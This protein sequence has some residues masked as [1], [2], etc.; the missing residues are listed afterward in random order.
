MPVDREKCTDW[1]CVLKEKP[2][3]L[4]SVL[5]IGWEEGIRMTPEFPAGIGRMVAPFTK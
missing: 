5:H 2:T 4:A 1:S 3:G